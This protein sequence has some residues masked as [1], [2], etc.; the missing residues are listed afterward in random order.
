MPVPGPNDIQQVLIVVGAHLR[1]EIADRPLAYQLADA[2]RLWRSDHA[3]W[4]NIN[5]EPVVLTD[6]W[7][8]N[9]EELQAKP[10]ISLGGPGVNALSNAFSKTMETTV[11]EDD[12]PTSRSRE[13]D[14]LDHDPLDRDTSDHDTSDHDT[15]DSDLPNTASDDAA[16]PTA[17]P[18]GNTPIDPH[19][20]QDP[21]DSQ[22]NTA[23]E[24]HEPT[25]LIQFDPE[26]TDLRC[27]IWGTDHGL[28]LKGVDLF[29]ENYLDRFLKAVA[30]QV[31]PKVD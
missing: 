10:T 20:D 12:S 16:G 22:G 25:V 1:A 11:Q 26:Y 3:A 14:P 28:T 21:Q 27:C 31:E 7:Y 19:A 5:L 18:P 8:L 2:I 29:I 9:N 6:L 17:P 24:P 30:T 4:L 15:P 13:E 23:P